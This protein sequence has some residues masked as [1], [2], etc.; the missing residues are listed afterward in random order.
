MIVPERDLNPFLHHR[1]TEVGEGWP[2]QMRAASAVV[3]RLLV[4]FIDGDDKEG[5]GSGSLQL[6]GWV[7]CVAPHLQGAMHQIL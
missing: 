6:R 2:G 5:E 3:R 1:Q 4:F 7:I